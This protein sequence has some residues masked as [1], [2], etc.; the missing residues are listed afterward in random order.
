MITNESKNWEECR[1]ALEDMG[2]NDDEIEFLKELI[3][4]K[5]DFC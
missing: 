1:N 4:K 2:R 5:D 3:D